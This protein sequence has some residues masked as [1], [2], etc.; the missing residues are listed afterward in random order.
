MSSYR[1]CLSGGVEFIRPFGS[2][3]SATDAFLFV[4]FAPRQTAAGVATFIVSVV[5][6]S[7][8]VGCARAIYSF[9]QCQSNAL[10]RQV[11]FILSPQAV[12]FE[13][14]AGDYLALS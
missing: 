9:P 2:I 8:S 13:S 12:G 1:S 4:C 14:S 10:Q 6:A 3:W 11:G 7:S 5:S